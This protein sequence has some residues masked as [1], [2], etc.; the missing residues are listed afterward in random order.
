MLF[1]QVQR[2]ILAKKY[3]EVRCTLSEA[4]NN[5]EVEYLSNITSTQLRVEK[6][7]VT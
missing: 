5:H 2:V 1:E 3:F 6:R 4:C 7:L